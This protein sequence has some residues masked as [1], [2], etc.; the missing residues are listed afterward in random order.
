MQNEKCKMQ[1]EQ[2]ARLTV[3][4]RLDYLATVLDVV[5]DLATVHGLGTRGAER[6]AFVVEEACA[7]VMEHAY[8]AGETGNIELSFTAQPGKLV[9]T[10]DDLGLPFDCQD[11]AQESRSGLGGVLGRTFQGQV[12]CLSRGRQGNR[13]ELVVPV[14]ARAP[15]AHEAEAEI[16]RAADAPPAEAA[17]PLTLRLMAPAD[18]EGITRC[19]YRTYGYTYFDDHLYDPDEVRRRVAAGREVN[20]VAVNEANEVAGYFEVQVHPEEPY[21][22]EAAT[23]VVDPRYR[24]HHLFE[25]MKGF[26]RD[27]AKDRGWRGLYSEAVTTHLFSQKGSLAVGAK[28]TGVL[29]ADLP[30]G[31]SFNA[32]DRAS[33]VRTAT[34]MLYLP[35]NPSP[36]QELWLP[37]RHA[38]M[39]NQTYQHCGLKRTVHAAAAEQP[40]DLAAGSQLDVHVDADVSEAYMTV[41]QA[42]ANLAKLLD[43]RLGELRR[44]S[45]DVAY[46]DLPLG[47]AAAMAFTG[48][49]E[50]LGFFFAGLVPDRGVGDV[51]RLQYLRDVAVDVPKI[52]VA[53]A[54]GKQL[55]DYVV[56]C[57]PA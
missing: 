21:L 37:A 57:R 9:F 50:K 8:P 23:A 45:V 24:G 30:A 32:I 12:R 25:R 6:T 33:V 22:A 29:L 2:T 56:S 16:A 20:C 5:R 4:A 44:Q 39:L 35:V 10:I 26:V 27:Y 15:L 52:Q 53:T 38:D 41:R 46:V 3:P 11:F 40:T 36:P 49:L 1:S 17:A 42:G 47:D 51:L 19:L 18:A 13:I 55:L 48:A 43:F 34:I 7:H 31:V 14:P 28:E 54:F